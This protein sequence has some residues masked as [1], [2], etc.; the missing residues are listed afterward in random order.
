MQW[1]VI[2]TS[3]NSA[4]LN[5]ALDK[6]VM[7]SII[8]GK[9]LPTIRFYRWQ[10]SAV[11]IGFFQSLNDEVDV[12]KCKELGVDIVRRQTGGGAVYHDYNGELTYSIIGPEALFPK[13]INKSYELI[14]GW[15][16]DALKDLGMSDASFVPINDIIVGG[17]KIS[18]NAQTRSS[19]LLLQ[20]G[21]ILWDLDVAKMFSLLKVADEK[22][23]DKMI[24]AVEERVT[25][26]KDHSSANLEQVEEAM[27]KAFTK[28]KE[29]AFDDFTVE[30]K[31]DAER[32]AREKYGNDEWN[33]KR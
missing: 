7:N 30:E 8:A 24:T 11:S 5:M 19:K 17:K 4:A 1:R 28:N 21:T 15:I 16:C 31:Q 3:T 10:P 33:Y 29:F 13:N 27:I 6:A 26:V 32:I 18:G 2:K 20:H 9:S 25:R 12:A 23:R 14:C 22:I